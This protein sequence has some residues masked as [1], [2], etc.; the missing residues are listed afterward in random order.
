MVPAEAAL[1]ALCD[2]DDRWHPDKLAVL[3]GAR[4]RPARL[5]RPAPGRRPRAGAAETLW[6]GRRNNSEDLASMLSPTPSPGRRRSSAASSLDSFFRS[7]TARL[8]VP[9][10]LAGGRGPARR[11]RL[12][13]SSALRLCAARG[14]GVRP[15][16]Q[17]I[18]GPG[19]AVAPPPAAA[20]D[21]SRLPCRRTSTVPRPQSPGA[22][23]APPLSERLT[24]AS[25]AVSSAFIAGDARRGL[26]VARRRP[27]APAAGAHRALERGR[28]GAGSRGRPPPLRAPRSAAAAPVGDASFPPG[29]F[30]QRRL[31]RWR[32]RMR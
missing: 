16:H 8:P 31:R 7:P 27:L 17:R 23:G 12:R 28:A 11:D 22:D 20:R 18:A 13:R 6:Q 14:G 15:R 26:R 10:P 29:S 19:R 21:S 4:L 25:V 30:N 2:Q 9:R 32:G 1:V 3:R 24:P 5:F